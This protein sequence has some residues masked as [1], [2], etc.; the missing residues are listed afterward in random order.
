MKFHNQIL[1]SGKFNL[2][3]YRSVY[4]EINLDY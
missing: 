4:I 1:I 3:D 2:L